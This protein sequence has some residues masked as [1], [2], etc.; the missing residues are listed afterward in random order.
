MGQY[1]EPK[2]KTRHD[3]R[4]VD[5][6]PVWIGVDKRSPATQHIMNTQQA[7]KWIKED[8]T[9]RKLKMETTAGRLRQHSQKQMGTS[10]WDV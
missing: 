5:P 8:P 6:T 7:E 2:P 4:V 3:V 1:M 9:N 10:I